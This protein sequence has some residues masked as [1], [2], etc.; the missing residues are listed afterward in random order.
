MKNIKILILSVLFFILFGYS[1]L[2]AEQPKASMTDFVYVGN[3]IV[4]GMVIVFLSLIIILL[5][6]SLLQF[7]E[8]KEKKEVIQ[9]AKAAA[10]NKKKSLKISSINPIN[11]KEK[12]KTID[13]HIKLAAITTIF[14]YE[15][16]IE[17]RSQMLLTMKR[18][19][20][21]PWQEST[22]LLMS[23]YAYKNMHRNG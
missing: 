21:S 2:M 20:V 23:N 18:A 15:N 6:V 4:A 3:I 5:V 8:K 14:L 19:K 11:K 7:I 1:T 9:K 10:G 16:E 17:K 12:K 13:H 22:R